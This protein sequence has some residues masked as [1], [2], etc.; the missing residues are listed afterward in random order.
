MSLFLV[1]VWCLLFVVVWCCV[2]STFS[3][4]NLKRRKEKTSR[5]PLVVV[6]VSKSFKTNRSRVDDVE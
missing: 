6:I 1:V 5:P 4:I 3:L 2:L